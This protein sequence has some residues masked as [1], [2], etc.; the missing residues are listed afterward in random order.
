MKRSQRQ[1]E[2]A[3]LD[4][5][6]PL[7]HAVSVPFWKS[8]AFIIIGSQL[9]F[10][11]SDVI[12]ARAMKAQGFTPAAFF[13]WWFLTYTVIR[14]VAVFGQLYIYAN[15]ELGR[16]VALFGAGSIVIGNVMGFLLFKETLSLPA[17]VGVSLA[18]CAFLAL[19]LLPAGIKP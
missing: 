17:Y 7:A 13:T 2:A 10:S 18:I 3:G 11:I 14:Q 15:M 19:A 4:P 12:G 9:L 16:T 1:D 8:P 5:S 6:S